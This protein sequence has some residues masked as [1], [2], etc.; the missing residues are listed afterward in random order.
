MVSTRCEQSDHK[1]REHGNTE[2]HRENNDRQPEVKFEVG[3]HT[4]SDGDDASNL[5]LSQARADA[6]RTQLIT[7][8]ID[9]SRL[10]TKVMENQ[11]Q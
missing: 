11:N 3:G 2:W 7:M 9:A 4:D 6:V 10:T 1:A 8:G 5:K